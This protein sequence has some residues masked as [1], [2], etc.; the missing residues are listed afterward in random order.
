MA[1]LT[2]IPDFI[3]ASSP[4][5]LRRLM[6]RNNIKRKAWFEYDIQFNPKDGKWYAWFLNINEEENVKALEED[7]GR[8]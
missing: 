7:N 6:L 1:D 4:K 2:A 8:E 5:G 3:S